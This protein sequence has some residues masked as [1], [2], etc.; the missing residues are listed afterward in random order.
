MLGVVAPGGYSGHEPAERRLDIHQGTKFPEANRP[1]SPNRFGTWIQN[2]ARKID[3]EG[4]ERTVSKSHPTASEFAF[5]NLDLQAEREFFRRIVLSNGCFKSTS[6]HRMDDLNAFVLPYLKYLEDW[7]LNIMDVAASSGISTQEW[8][9]QLLSA[10][11]DARVIGTDLYVDALH[12]PGKK[13][14]ILLDK[15]MNVIHL[16]LLGSGVHPRVLKIL[17]SSG[18]NTLLRAVMKSGITAQ[19]LNLVS[20]AVRNVPVIEEDIENSDTWATERFHVIR[21]A[22][23]LNRV[24][25]PEHRLRNMIGLLRQRLREGGLLIVSRTHH[26]GTNHASVFRLLKDSL[27]PLGRLG[28][29]SE[30]ENLVS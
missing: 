6:P 24:Y 13:V 16:G 19:P 15:D 28:K 27:T 11:V 23:I 12:L 26:D 2:W 9:D 10:G 3:H 25:F 17:R 14:D 5:A 20:K 7:P 22:N 4:S 1:G 18:L 8:Y 30:I 21:A 29:G